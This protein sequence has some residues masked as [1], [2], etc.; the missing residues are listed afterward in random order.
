MQSTLS[1]IIKEQLGDHI[2]LTVVCTLF[3]M[4]LSLA[5]ILGADL[6]LQ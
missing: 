2:P 6:N 3:E 4:A 1:P 5:T